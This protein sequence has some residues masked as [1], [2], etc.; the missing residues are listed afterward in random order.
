[1][2]R[3]QPERLPDNY[4]LVYDVVCEQ[5]EGMHTTAAEIYAEARRR[6]SGIGHSTVYRALDR[7]RDLGLILEVRV[8]GGA[9][10]LYEPNRPGHAHFMCG[11]CG[12]VE[13]IEFALAPAQFDE[14][15][16]T[17][18]VEVTGVSLTLQGVCAE[19]RVQGPEPA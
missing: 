19:C 14:V 12:R 17:R 10:A 4:R 2:T 1:M 7:L 18:G 16:A 15:A 6:R 8:P 13:D 11:R 3:M 9:S 5:V